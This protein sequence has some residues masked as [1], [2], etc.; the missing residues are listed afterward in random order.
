M[1]KRMYDG[2]DDDADESNPELF[3]LLYAAINHHFNADD[4]NAKKYWGKA[5]R[6]V[7]KGR[8]VEEVQFKEDGFILPLHLA[9]QHSAPFNLIK[10][11]VDQYDAGCSVVFGDEMPLIMACGYPR[12][13]ARDVNDLRYD[14][15]WEKVILLLMKKNPAAIDA[16]KNTALHL[17][18]EHNPSLELVQ[19][20]IELHQSSK[21]SVTSR[22]RKKK[23][24]ERNKKV[25]LLEMRDEQNQLPLHVAVEQVA[26]TDVVLKILRSYPEAAKCTRE[27]HDG[28]LPLHCAVSF[29]CSGNVLTQIIRAFPDA[30]LQKENSGNTPLHMLFHMET[31]I[32]RWNM[33]NKSDDSNGDA[34][35][36][37]TAIC[38]LLLEYIPEA[39]M[40]STLKTSNNSGFTVVEAAN[41]CAKVF[42]VPD[43]LIK[44]LVKAE[45]GKLTSQIQRPQRTRAD[46]DLNARDPFD[47]STDEGSNDSE[48]DTSS[49]DSSDSEG[50]G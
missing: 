6:R 41:E 25:S 5:K 49:D 42:T 15:E 18:L 10:A 7:K 46:I 39:K 21:T 23:K 30:L 13:L 47:Q 22:V 43:D 40:I 4:E 20:M 38:R 45:N 31:N 44:L 1:S 34:P 26:A 3:R 11:L 28:S 9:I 50:E 33:G 37:E 2:S 14:A 36:S 17:V 8:H 24:T 16:N 27:N 48:S 32:S 19:G 35:L 29:G 12:R